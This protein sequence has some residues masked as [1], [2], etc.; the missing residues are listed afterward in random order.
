[1][2]TTTDTAPRPRI[3]IVD[4]EPGNVRLL[5][6]LLEEWGHGDLITTSDPTEVPD[7]FRRERPDLLLLD[8]MMPVLDGYGF[9]EQQLRD[10]SLSSIPVI[11]ITA[12][13]QAREK[14][15]QLGAEA[16][17]RKPISPPAL[18]RTIRS[19]CRHPS[20]PDAA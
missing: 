16:F 14:A 3:L 7:L 12:D 18:L 15:M 11:V 9:R 6:L 4:D 8:L 20:E 10:P 2:Q 5:S 17:F 19:F 1:M 13:G